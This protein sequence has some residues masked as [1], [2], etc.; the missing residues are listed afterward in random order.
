MKKLPTVECVNVN[1]KKIIVNRHDQEANPEKY[2]L[3][4]G[5]KED[6]TDK[7]GAAASGAVTTDNGD[8][9][10]LTKA[11]KAKQAAIDKAKADK[12]KGK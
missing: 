8:G 10:E 3:Y 12:A 6:D 2:K 5:K 9:D 1:G 7:T 11:E 4:T